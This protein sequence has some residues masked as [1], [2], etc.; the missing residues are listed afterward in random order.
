MPGARAR[1]RPVRRALTTVVVVAAVLGLVVWG[2]VQLLGN[3]V[4]ERAQAARCAAHLDGTDWYLSPEQAQ[5][6]ALFAAMATER[7][8]PARAVTIAIATALQ[9][10][11]MINIAYGDR[12]SLGLFQQRPSQGWGTEE[13]VMDPIYATGRFYDG[14]VDVPGYLELEV[15]QAAQA[16]QR[17]GFP[18]AYAQ[19]EVRARA[20]AS[21]LT[22]H[23]PAT[24]TCTLPALSAADAGQGDALRA[25]LL[26]DFP[27]LADR[28]NGSPAEVAVGPG[29]LA[30]TPPD[31]LGWVL[32]QWAVTQADAYGVRTVTVADQRWMRE[33]G[34]WSAVAGEQ[35]P[36]GAVQ[37]DVGAA[38]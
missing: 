5:N 38:D 19:H 3:L 11:R 13:Q 20:W 10:S 36:A 15:T 21:G 6:A 26:R 16:V 27:A 2:V 8:L 22:G 37:I 32:A 33:A 25:R 31:R 23:S 30:D 4:P 1:R 29:E 17:S 34:T 35:L 14:L 24:I 28:V 12:D 18:D 9:E 7:G